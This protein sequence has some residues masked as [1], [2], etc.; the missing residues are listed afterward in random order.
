[1]KRILQ[2]FIFFPVILAAQV[3]ISIPDTSLEQG[4]QYNVPIFLNDV[5][6]NEQIISIELSISWDNDYLS[7]NNL[8]VI[9][10]ITENWGEPFYNL[11]DNQLTIWFFGAE[12]INNSGIIAFVEI[13]VED[14]A[15]IEA[16]AINIPHAYINEGNPQVETD[17][18]EIIILP[19]DIIPPSKIEDLSIIN[20]GSYFIEVEWTSPGDDSTSGTA[21][22]YD[23][24]YS[25]YE[26]DESNWN[27]A[28]QIQSEPYPLSSGYA[29]SCT[30]EDL[31]S[32]HHYFIGI[33][34]IDDRGNI[35]SLSNVVD[36]IT[37]DVIP[38]EILII[39]P[40]SFSA[41]SAGHLDSICW[42]AN[43][44][45]GIGYSK[46][47]FS[48]DGGNNFL[49]IDSVSGHDESYY[50]INWQAP[51]IVSDECLIKIEAFDNNNLFNSEQSDN[52]FSIKD[53]DAPLIE[54][55]NP[56]N[57]SVYYEYDTLEIQWSAT[58]N[59]EVDSVVIQFYRVEDG[60]WITVDSGS[61]ISGFYNWLIPGGILTEMGKIY[62][63]AFDES[64]NY[65]TKSS[66]GYFT[67]LDNTPPSVSISNLA[68]VGNFDTTEI[69]WSAS[70]NFGLKSHYLYFSSDNGST[71]SLIDSTSGDI[72]SYSWVVPNVL[73]DSCRIQIVTY[74]LMN[75]TAMDTTE[76]F[77]ILDNFPPEINVLYP[78]E[79]F[80]IP[81]YEKMF[82]SWNATDNIQMDSVL[83]YFSNNGGISFAYQGAVP[84][85]STQLHFNIPA[86]VTDSALI[87]LVA[88]DIFG[89]EGIGYSDLFS[90]I[91]NTPPEIT[92]LVPVPETNYGTEDI[93]NIEWEASDNVSL[94]WAEIYFSSDS[95]AQFEFIDS[96][97]AELDSYEWQVP[98]SVV[99]SNCR[100]SIEV[101]DYKN[102]TSA[103]TSCIFSIFDNTRPVVTV[104]TPQ[105]G[106]SI[107]EHE[108]I[109]VTW[110]ATDNIQL[111]SVA[112]YYSKDGG[113]SGHLM[114][115]VPADSN[116]FT[117][118]IPPGVT[119]SATIRVK[120]RDIYNNTGDDFSP[121]FSVT[122]NTPPSVSI[123][124]LT[125]CSIDDTVEICWESSDN[126]GI[127]LHHIFF[128]DNNAQ[129]FSLIDSVNGS[130]NSYNWLVPNIASD[131]CRIKITS[132]DLVNLSDSDT[133][134]IFSI[135]DGIPPQISILSPVGGF[136]IPEYEEITVTWNAY[137]N[138]EMD[139]VRIYYSNTG[140]SSFIYQGSVTGDSE[141]FN[142]DVPAGV[143]DSAQI[144]LVAE[145]IFGN[146][147]TDYSE[148]FSISDNTPPSIDLITQ[149]SSSRLEI[150]S[151]E[152]I[153]W[154]ASDN[155]A[156]SSINIYYSTNDGNTLKVIST[157]EEN[158]GEY[159]WLIP[160]D[161][162]KQCKIKVVAIDSVGLYGEDISEGLFT[163]IITYPKLIFHNTFISPLDTV[164]LG[165][166]Q[167]L[168]SEQFDVGLI[169]NS[170]VIGDMAYNYQ[171]ENNN[172]Y[173]SIYQ[174]NSFVSGDTLSLILL[175]DK[176]TNIFGYGLD[177]NQNEVFEGS[178]VDNDTVTVLLKYSGDFDSNDQVDFNDLSLFANAWYSKDF[179]Y[180]LGPVTGTV[181]HVIT[182][183]D[184]QFNIDDAMTFGRMWNWFVG[185]GK[186][187]IILPKLLT[188]S[189]FTVTQEG[190]KISILTDPAI[191]K[192][193]V[194][195]Y[196]KEKASVSR[197][198]ANLTKPS[199]MTF[200][201]FTELPDS[202]IAE[203]AY[204]NFS[205]ELDDSPIS[206]NI[207][208][209][210]RK[211]FIIT[212][213]VE[214]INTSGE[215]IFS[216][217]K[218]I[219]YY[220]IPDKFSLYQN[221]PNPFNAQ[222]II[223]YGIPLE[224]HVIIKIYDLL[225]K[226]VRT[227]YNNNH[228]PNYYRIIWDGK[229][230]FG[231]ELASGIYFCSIVAK[232]DKNKF[233]KTKKMI[234][235]R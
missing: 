137:D 26:M 39:H 156:V 83:I 234:L 232:A 82:V 30:I 166:S 79:G 229:D 15:P 173:V 184:S 145:D 103:D 29:Q 226:E 19:W 94:T 161:P 225:G 153:T 71:F 218:T 197:E 7:I 205:N 130:E 227:L 188:Q 168:K 220:P 210:H 133:S 74:D 125:E 162:S 215:L 41:I 111:E 221:Y 131:S 5:D 163:I 20:V 81:E 164:K 155:A 23:I 178:P 209:K 92:I 95:S 59:I 11:F 126:T 8:S 132:Y 88:K 154:A 99:S 14:D 105:E 212:I 67:I 148:Y 97:N 86:G 10:A 24:R 69:V 207:H 198:Q 107:P 228:D 9:G 78:T 142:F 174:D 58:D 93:I 200:S 120:A 196:D 176:V 28:Q 180:E 45:S 87:E 182:M 114:G 16:T 139:S 158:D 63:T 129:T 122:D 77:T 213:G 38:P 4:L 167:A 170:A 104:L 128:S 208:S 206:F 214:G 181:P 34:S 112:I 235:L 61:I 55:M 98:D 223:S 117:F 52:Y 179:K 75:L 203:Y 189:D 90:V 193:I 17:Y 108:E 224:S 18:S 2:I 12:P 33:K 25:E 121:L 123:F 144:K 64:G 13:L 40:T 65:D 190:S 147:G 134:D 6:S 185:L 44:L 1:M 91:D 230:D 127:R 217:I 43:D 138:I 211:D 76:I 66:S 118:S 50:S 192:R 3:T 194:L 183:P 177:G 199:D 62:I 53:V 96:V 89:N 85:D 175:A 101:S 100:M 113:Y 141:Q 233:T 160:N 80:S 102:N 186:Y 57:G 73:S 135:V 22:S 84:S 46:I 68:T 56:Q 169:L 36:T 42:E 48:V 151:L 136:S 159:S 60:L 201:F 216:A 231:R 116:W 37:V 47:F 219:Q 165:F 202:G 49:N 109:N 157:D 152:N 54:V 31:S 27:S 51:N 191:G 195:I 204:Y 124:N 35:S 119:D 72:N 222:T 21:E 110:N 143:T 187:T 70:D 146:E 172:Q 140:Y 106:F 150:G 32:T 149:L 115:V 171:F